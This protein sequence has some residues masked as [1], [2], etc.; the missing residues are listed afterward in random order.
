MA[1]KALE[2]RFNM[3]LSQKLTQQAGTDLVRYTREGDRVVLPAVLGGTL[4][5][6]RV[7]IDAKAAVTRGLRNETERRLKGLFE[8]LLK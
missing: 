3:V 2:G 8:G 6:P 7:T 5:R 4:E 1:T